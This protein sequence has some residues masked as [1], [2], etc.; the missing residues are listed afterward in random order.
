MQALGAEHHPRVAHAGG[1]QCLDIQGQG[2]KVQALT[3]RRTIRIPTPP[4]GQHQPGT[5]R[6]TACLD[7]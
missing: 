1:Q 3:R 4:I 2:G 5:R 6:E 7:E